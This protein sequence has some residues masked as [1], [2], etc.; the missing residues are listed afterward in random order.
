MCATFILRVEAEGGKRK[1]ERK[2][3][4]GEK[5]EQEKEKQGRSNKKE[6]M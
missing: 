2:A 5:E 6:K 3:T 1:N 4:K